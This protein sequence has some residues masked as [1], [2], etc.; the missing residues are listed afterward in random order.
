MINTVPGSRLFEN[1]R[2]ILQLVRNRLRA[3]G[4]WD[5]LVEDVSATEEL[6]MAE[7]PEQ[8]AEILRLYDNL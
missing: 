1:T 5:E 4:N 8:L 7:L 3:A 2:E 6:A